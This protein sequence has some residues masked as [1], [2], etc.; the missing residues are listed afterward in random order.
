MWLLFGIAGII[1]AVLNLLRF[2]MR[3]EAKW[4]RFL[5]LSFTALTLCAFLGQVNGWVIL[6]DWSALA[7]VLPSTSKIFWILTVASLIINAISLFPSDS[8]A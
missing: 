1:T 8:A 4:F 7:D 2:L 5:S 3:R 6:E